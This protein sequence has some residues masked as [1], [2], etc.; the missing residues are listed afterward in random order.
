[1]PY[2][3]LDVGTSQLKASLVRE[4]GTVLHTAVKAYP[5][6]FPR[7]GWVELDINEVYGCVL[8]ALREL[9]A[10]SGDIKAMAIS[11]IGEMLVFADRDGNALA[12]GIVYL[13]TRCEETAAALL[14]R[15]PARQIHGITGIVY[16]SMYSLFQY[17]WTQ[18][19][20]PAVFR[21]AKQLFLLGDYLTYRLCGERLIDPSSA[22]RTMLLDVHTRD[23]SSVMFD[24]FAIDQRLFSAVCPSGTEAGTLRPGV[25]SAT[26]LPPATRVFVGCHDQIA[27]TIGAG[28]LKPGDL[29]AG[30]GSTESLNVVAAQ[31][32]VDFSRCF[33]NGISIEPF[34]TENQYVLPLGQLS[35]GTAIRWF[36]KQHE[37][38]YRAHDSERSVYEVADG[39][40]AA[41]TDGLFF[42]PYLS[43]ANCMNT[44]NQVPASLIGISAST[45]VDQMYRAVLEG[46]SFESRDNLNRLRGLGIVPERIIAS[47]GCA[48]SECMM[49]IKADVLQKPIEILRGNHAA[50]AGLCMLC[51]VGLGDAADLSQARE[52][53]THIS[54]TVVPLNS[55]ARTFER[56]LEIRDGLGKLFG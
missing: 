52:R 37:A 5:L 25:A 24:T 11:S 50:A 18:R 41:E 46:V 33:D 2:I 55:Y 36:V 54:H 44:G 53:F 15:M 40:C 17:H 28:V 1:M 27:A 29:S 47:G 45:T 6:R 48:K 19:E 16:H 26:G 20:R 12:N 7:A 22:S 35:H 3:G 49:Q 56:Y 9:A 21:E 30:E 13:D 14:A 43:K 23:W 8:E 10:L 42:I 39:L 31:E 51:A 4:D 32:T 34:V 38:Y